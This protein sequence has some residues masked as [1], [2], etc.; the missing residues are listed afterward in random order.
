MCTEVGTESDGKCDQS[1]RKLGK[2]LIGAI[3][4]T[5]LKKI[6]SSSTKNKPDE[7]RRSCNESTNVGKNIRYSKDGLHV[8]H[9]SKRRLSTVTEKNR[10]IIKCTI[11][12][13]RTEIAIGGVTRVPKNFLLER[14]LQDELDRRENQNLADKLCSLCYEEIEVFDGPATCEFCCWKCS[15]L[16]FSL[17]GGRSLWPLSH[18]SMRNLQGGTFETTDHI[19]AYY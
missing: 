13:H 12:A 5:H 9:S 1:H 2:P 17:V 10:T 4:S 6:F 3:S 15:F 7:S 14:Q 19:A 16:F 11:C 18:Q 8:S